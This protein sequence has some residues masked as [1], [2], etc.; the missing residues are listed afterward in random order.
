MEN[1][2]NDS[3]RL[4]AF[5]A[6]YLKTEILVNQLDHRDWLGQQPLTSYHWLTF[7]NTYVDSCFLEI[8]KIPRDD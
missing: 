5:G 1:M 2:G 8:D 6:A 3:F 4:W 7:V